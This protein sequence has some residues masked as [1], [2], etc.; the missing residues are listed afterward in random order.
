MKAKEFKR[1]LYKA[2]GSALG[3]FRLIEE[4]FE[5]KNSPRDWLLEIEN[6]KALKKELGN[7]PLY[8]YHPIAKIK[9][10]SLDFFR[11]FLC[12]NRAGEEWAAQRESGISYTAKKDRYAL[13]ELATFK[14]C[15]KLYFH[16]HM[17]A[18]LPY[19]G[20]FLLK[21]YFEAILFA[22]LT[23][24]GL[25]A[26]EQV[27]SRHI[28]FF[29]FLNEKEGEEIKAAA[30]ERTEN[31]IRNEAKGG[32]ISFSE[33]L[34]KDWQGDGYKLVLGYD[35]HINQKGKKR[36]YQRDLGIHYL[37]LGTEP[38][39]KLSPRY[40]DI[41]EALERGGGDRVALVSR[42]INKINIQFDSG[43]YK[44]AQDGIKRTDLLVR[45]I[46]AYDFSK[47]EAMLSGY[48]RYCPAWDICRGVSDGTGY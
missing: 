42:L 41:I 35:M 10:D 17:G 6:I 39:G 33:V 25:N 1:L 12:E 27:F 32:E 43:S 44:F 45:E 11:G 13:H 26:S 2:G 15:P 48:C 31:F 38:P 3:E 20:R 4:Y 19:K 21:A 30:Y 40:G 28:K 29:G 23:G 5:G 18:A 46:E 7:R 9:G 22:D 47:A 34:P 37:S 24:A 16:R 14:L 8:R 36:L